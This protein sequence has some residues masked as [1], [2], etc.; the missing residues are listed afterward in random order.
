MK[1]MSNNHVKKGAIHIYN[2]HIKALNGESW[3]PV[4]AHKFSHYI[5][6]DQMGSHWQ[7]LLDPAN[8]GQVIR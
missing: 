4:R 6:Q 7:K 8:Y 3:K 5:R 2:E 1:G